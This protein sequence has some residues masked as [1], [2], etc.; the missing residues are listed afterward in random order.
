[1]RI[2]RVHPRERAAF[3]ARLAALERLA[4]YPLGDDTFQLDHGP[5]YFAF[6]DRLGDVLYGVALEGDQV[7]AVGCGVLRRVVTRR[8]RAPRRAWY[9]G[10]LKVHPDFRGRRIPLRLLGRHFWWNYP[11]APRG[12]GF[13]MD[14]PGSESRVAKLFGHWRWSPVRAAGTLGLWSLDADQAR[15]ARPLLE[16]HRGPVTFRSLEGIKDLVLGSTGRRMPLLHLE[17]DTGVPPPTGD[18]ARVGRLLPDPQPDHVHMLCAPIASP[19]GPDDPLAADLR[20]LGL[21]PGATATILAHRMGRDCD[22]RFAL[23]SEI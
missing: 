6:F 7:A 15:A 13:T 20:A 5:D 22:W 12:Y 19:A 17:W 4:T 21:H 16:R 8:G 2:T 23:T 14:A 3:Q 11:R 10:D 1:M 18:P 9:L